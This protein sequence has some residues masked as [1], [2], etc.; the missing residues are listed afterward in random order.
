VLATKFALAPTALAAVLCSGCTSRDVIARVEIPA[1]AAPGRTDFGSGRVGLVD[2]AGNALPSARSTL[3]AATSDVAGPSATAEGDS[4]WR[5]RGSML[6]FCEWRA[7]GRDDCRLAGY[8]GWNQDG[9][10]LL[11]GAVAFFPTILRTSSASDAVVDAA[12]RRGSGAESPAVLR[13][14]L[15]EQGT[16]PLEATEERAIW[17]TAAAS[18]V[19]GPQPAFLCAADPAPTC[20]A[21]PFAVANVVAVMSVKEGKRR[22]PVLWAQGG[23]VVAGFGLE[24]RDLGMFRC[25]SRSGLPS[26]QR[27]KEIP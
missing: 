4:L 15:T 20:R 8:E 22:V 17:I 16:A 5:V 19:F 9:K 23:E 1:E 24:T 12:S 11:Q 3:V 6:E 21:L 27:A 7:D 2:D 14:L 10:V 13:V 26:C 18:T 25:V